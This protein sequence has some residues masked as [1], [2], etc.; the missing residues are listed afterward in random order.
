MTNCNKPGF[1]RLV[2]TWWNWQVCW[3]LLKNCNKPVKLTTCNISLPFL[4]RWCYQ[5]IQIYIVV[6]PWWSLK[7]KIHQQTWPT[8]STTWNF[9]SVSVP[10]L[11]NASKFNCP[12]ASRWVP[13]LMSAPRRAAPLMP[14]ITTV[15]VAIRSAHGQAVT[16][17]I[18]AL[19]PQVLARPSYASTPARSRNNGIKKTN[20][21][22]TIT[23]G[24]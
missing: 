5:C 16:R 19:S 7:N 3:N 14:H 20:A 11:S 10:V 21:A 12:K 17:T 22:T 1:N 8:K 2:A 15:G 4:V 6:I 13:P 24:V 9:P 18:R 23:R